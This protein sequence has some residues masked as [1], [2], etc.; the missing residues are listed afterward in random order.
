MG[1]VLLFVSS[2]PGDNKSYLFFQMAGFPP[3]IALTTANLETF[4][5]TM[6]SSAQNVPGTLSPLEWTYVGHCYCAKLYRYHIE[7]NL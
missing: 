4:N 6:I 5:I 2:S 7:P 3:G 1:P